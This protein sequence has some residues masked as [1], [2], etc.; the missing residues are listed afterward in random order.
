MSEIESFSTRVAER[1]PELAARVL[2]TQPAQAGAELLGQLPEGIVAEILK[3][4][5][6]REATR[7]LRLLHPDKTA[8]TLGLLSPTTAASLMRGLPARETESLL[9]NT[10]Q[11]VAKP[12]RF[13]LRY[14][15]TV[16]GACMQASALLLPRDVDVAGARE[17]IRSSAEDLERQLL[18]VDRN[19][20]LV[21]SITT[22][23]LLREDPE[24]PLSR[25]MNPAPLAL[26]SRTGIHA[27]AEHPGWEHWDPLPV[28]NR[29]Q[30]VVGLLHHADLRQALRSRS[31]HRNDSVSSSLVE[32]MELSWHGM[33]DLLEGSLKLSAG[34]AV[35]P[36]AERH[37]V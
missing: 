2:E 1:R 6:P 13:L 18:V 27:A 14:P 31:H 5:V 33:A 34:Q 20:R 11:N 23:S 35:N 29:E 8:R 30:R 19:Q 9:A 10:P 21:G 28:I 12:L 7:R 32:L 4:M 25:L 36:R 37:D 22:A 17:L 24:R 15:A 3:R 26:H 16:V